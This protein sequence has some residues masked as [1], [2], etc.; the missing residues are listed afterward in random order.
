MYL[1]TELIRKKRTGQEL[2]LHEL[3]WMIGAYLANEVKD[4]Q[5]SAWLMAVCLKGM[6]PQETVY[7]TQ[8][9]RDSG[10]VFDLQ[11]LNKYCVDKHST[12]GIGDKTSMIIAPLAAAAGLAVPMV[13]GR[14]LGHTGGTLD[15]LESIPHFSTS[16]SPEKFRSTLESLGFAIVGQTPEMCPADKK[17]YALRDVTSTVD[18]IPLIC[19]SIMSKKLAEGL[20]GLVLDVKFGSGAFMKDLN[21]AQ[22]LARSLI[23]IGNGS[24]VK[25]K[26][27]LTNMN[28]P[29][30]HKIGN[31]LE[32]QECVDIMNNK[33][34]L[35]DGVD[36]YADTRELSLELCAHMLHLSKP[37]INF[38]DCK[39]EVTELLESGAALK[40][41][42]QL[43]DVQGQG[44]PEKFEMPY[45]P[46]PLV[47]TKDGV[48]EGMDV[49]QIGIAAIEIGVGRKT[50]DGKIDYWAGFEMNVKV[51]S[52]IK[53]GQTL[54]NIFAKN[55]QTIEKQLL[56]AITIGT[57][58]KPS[59]LIA[60]VMQ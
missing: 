8:V 18:S 52:P 45:A 34:C 15:K 49:E 36:F 48:I 44:Y 14:G 12:G 16:I 30:G 29:L 35:I 2:T 60:E 26:A 24:N 46:Y 57:S 51:G 40:K 7:L 13:A 3:Q 1:A 25:T 38:E 53:K 23:E 37:Q 5:I 31:A 4:Y 10:E 58:A 42:N 47:A 41:F 32:I 55:P 22:T 33:K 27:L 43:C 21:S 54:L 20:N 39:R 50:V 28:Q 6:T 56:N 9:M 19:A 17:L 11:Y 59:P